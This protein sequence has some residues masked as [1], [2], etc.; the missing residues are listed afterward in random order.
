MSEGLGEIEADFEASGASKA[1]VPPRLDD[2]NFEFP[3]A[4]QFTIAGVGSFTADGVRISHRLRHRD[5]LVLHHLDLLF[6]EPVGVVGSQRLRDVAMGP[7]FGTTRGRGGVLLQSS[8]VGSQDQLTVSNIGSSGQDGV[9]C[10]FEEDEVGVALQWAPST[11]PPPSDGAS[12]GLSG[13][14]GR[15]TAPED[16]VV[17]CSAQYGNAQFE[18]VRSAAT[19]GPPLKVVFYLDDLI[20]GVASDPTAALQVST[21]EWPS[22]AGVE[23]GDAPGM[24]TVSWGWDA[25]VSMQV[26]TE[27]AVQADEVRLVLP[28]LVAPNQEAQRLI[29]TP[30]GSASAYGLTILGRRTVIKPPNPNYP[31]TE[32]RGLHAE[33]IVHRDIATRISNIGSS[34]ED[35][36]MVEFEPTSA[37]GI[38]WHSS[39]T[40]AGSPGERIMMPTYGTTSGDPDRPI[41]LGQLW[42]ESTGSEVYV[43][44]DLSPLGVGGLIFN[45]YDN[46]MLVNSITAV[47]DAPALSMPLPPTG[48]TA[49]TGANGPVFYL[50]LVPD[51]QV[52]VVSA[53]TKRMNKADLIEVLPSETPS[54]V[55]TELVALSLRASS[56]PWVVIDSANPAYPVD[57]PPSRATPTLTLYPNA[58]N[59]FNPRTS[60]AFDLDRWGPVSLRIYDVRGQL[61]DV[62]HDGFLEAGHHLGVWD[63]MDSGGHSVASG[64]YY[65]RLEAAGESQTRKMSLVR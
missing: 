14:A 52:S 8:S 23:N 29:L 59:P 11:L 16:P 37:L 1:F 60:I 2:R 36:V 48:M 33:G 53:P 43:G 63:G 3:P 22:S 65:L 26:G 24:S 41:I 64:V 54:V 44:A 6:T 55:P 28:S 62:L 4:T 18:I 7:Y 49:R 46:G 20:V 21:S 15:D 61:V 45:L 56:I 42:N 35:G 10:D 39:S 51:T 58:P 27:P 57:A 17:A 19:T 34:G 12:I 50:E 30:P 25:P 9:A 31:Y 40:G 38:Q 32:L 5:R 13:D 47:N